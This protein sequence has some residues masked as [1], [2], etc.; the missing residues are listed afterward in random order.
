[1]SRVQSRSC[2]LFAIVALLC[3]VIASYG[4]AKFAGRVIDVL[5]G[6]TVAVETNAGRVTVQLQYIDVPGADEAYG[7]IVRG[8]LASL[9]QGKL[10]EFQPNRISGS[11]TIGRLTLNGTDISLQLLRDGAARHEP[12][13]R[14]GQ[15]PDQ[16]AEYAY[17]QEKA[18]EERR[19]IWAAA[20]AVQQSVVFRPDEGSQ[21]LR[22]DVDKWSVFL[23]PVTPPSAAS[24]ANRPASDTRTAGRVAI[25]PDS[26]VSESQDFIGSYDLASREGFT[27]SP[28][29]AAK[30]FGPRTGADLG[31]RV[32]FVY[33]GDPNA[34]EE[35]G[36]I[37]TFLSESDDLKF[38]GRNEL[39]LIADKQKLYIGNAKR[40]FRRNAN[41]VQEMLL[42]SVS[43]ST[44]EKLIT[45][46]ALG[47]RLSRASGSI[48]TRIQPALKQLLELS[49]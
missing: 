37:L 13:D 23:K 9:T 36:F 24:R 2:T 21:Q 4:Q 33:R 26:S 48:D 1:M 38:D 29:G 11:A 5:D 34:I 8:H 12:A 49:N 7:P 19:G 28:I 18:R 15:A 35:R 40:L 30:L 31:V 25:W 20:A 14:S 41:G 47:F 39:S 45:A 10:V 46:K 43:R 16:A 42:Y 6:R 27:A 32:V 3:G 44:L 17:N 22:H